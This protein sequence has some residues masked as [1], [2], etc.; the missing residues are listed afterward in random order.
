MWWSKL[1]GGTIFLGPFN[2]PSM[3]WHLAS[4]YVNIPQFSWCNWGFSPLVK[5]LLNTTPNCLVYLMIMPRS[6]VFQDYYTV[7]TNPMDLSTIMKRL[8]NKY[9][10]QA[11][12]CIQ[13]L[14]T[15]FTNCYVY[16]QVRV[17]F[18]TCAS[19]LWRV[20]I[21]YILVQKWGGP[22]W[23]SFSFYSPEMAS[24]S[25]LRPWRSFVRRN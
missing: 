16:N 11:L 6:F 24:F 21:R 17:L 10:W 22:T 13:D 3:Q 25:W 12:E 15:M 18:F 19:Y 14:N 5:Y 4:Q 7:I 1:Y 20:W 9:Y 23:M 8:K 2:G